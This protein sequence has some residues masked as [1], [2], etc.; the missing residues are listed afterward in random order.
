[1]IEQQNLPFRR[2]SGRTGIMRI[3]LHLLGRFSATVDARPPRAVQMSA[4]RRRAVLAYLALQPTPTPKP[5]NASP[6]CC[7]AMR[8]TIKRGRAFANAC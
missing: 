6:P 2:S 7:G 4:P 3:D 8:P 5:A 1:M